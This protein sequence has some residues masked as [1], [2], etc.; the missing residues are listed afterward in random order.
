MS[1]ED[2]PRND[3]M[4]VHTI[5]LNVT[6]DFDKKLKILRPKRKESS[7]K[8]YDFKRDGPVPSIGTVPEKLQRSRMVVDWYPRI[9]S[10]QSSTA[11]AQDVEQNETW[12][13]EAH[14]AF[15]NYDELYFKLEQFKRERSWYNLNIEKTKLK[16][17]LK[18]NT[19]YRIAI[20]P[21]QMEFNS[22]TNV[23]TWQ[24]IALE[25]LKRYTDSY[26]QYCKASYIEPR[27]ELRDL[28]REDDNIPEADEYKLF[29]D[30]SQEALVNKIRQFV[31]EITARQNDLIDLGELKSAWFETHLYQPILHA[32]RGSLINISPVSLN[33]SEFQFVKDL[34][35]Y[36]GTH[37]NQLETDGV[38][39]FLL[40]NESRGK[41]VGFIEA[42]NFY[43]DFILWMLKGHM[44]YIAFID[45]HGLR[46]DGNENAKI[47][48]ADEIKN[49]EQRLSDD[50]VKLN[51]FIV[52]PSNYAGLNWSQSKEQL[53]QQHVLFMN[54][55][56]VTYISTILSDM[57][58]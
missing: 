27:L 41:G 44:Q 42:K 24:S 19:W 46:H 2:L 57:Q 39:I 5:P 50:T 36:L 7:G 21:G 6:H 12:F 33:E 10:I 52:S 9:Q 1:D 3:N 28:T 43:P 26:Y 13:S 54:E 11:I 17:L 23:A 8:E 55:D 53:R 38:E 45:P 40:R 37:R 25:L 31:D 30:A 34:K 22:F 51:S 48:L 56:S 35:S 15:L 18:D 58:T 29:V 20:P 49:I 16:E 14:L 32:N 47:A 4:F